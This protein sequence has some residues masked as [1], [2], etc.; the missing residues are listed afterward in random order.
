MKV[1]KPPLG[2]IINSS[3]PLSKE[4][5]A[6]YLFNENSG[7]T[8]FDSSGNRWNTGTL[9]NFGL[10]GTTS[11]WLQGKD[12]GA[13]KFDGSNDYVACGT[14][15]VTSGDRTISALFKADAI[16]ATNMIVSK[17]NAAT[18]VA[19]YQIGIFTGGLFLIVNGTS[20][21][22]SV[23]SDIAPSVGVWYHLVGIVR[24][25]T[26]YVYVNGLIQTNTAALP[27]GNE[28]RPSDPL[29]IG[30]NHDINFPFSGVIDNVM[31]WDRAL[32]DSEI[33]ALYTNPY[34]MFM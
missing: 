33:R 4:L 1:T 34:Q 11:N 23:N 28:S 19:N 13:L 29:R 17:R 5:L 12:G 18:F 32:T 31:I 3:H 2:S 21:S 9:T 20:I 30:Q 26:L 25:S 8:I 7:S 15:C 24:E 27:A 14:G 10:S 6:A 16:G 22:V